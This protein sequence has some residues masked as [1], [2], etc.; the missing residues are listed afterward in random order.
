MMTSLLITWSRIPVLDSCGSRNVW[1]W[2]HVVIVPS[3]SYNEGI[4]LGGIPKEITQRNELDQRGQVLGMANFQRRDGWRTK[5]G[6]WIYKFWT[7]S[8][9]TRPNFLH[10][11]AVFRTIWSKERMLPKERML[12]KFGKPVYR[13]R[14]KWHWRIQG[15]AR[16]ARRPSG[17]RNSF[18][19]M[20][21]KTKIF[22]ITC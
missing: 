21:L 7:C 14:Q 2:K 20:Q 17:R 10:I 5:N 4:W 22:S 9:S 19:F 8:P 12:L 3:Q 15:G 6:W 18:I 1:S 13:K 11:H 16:D